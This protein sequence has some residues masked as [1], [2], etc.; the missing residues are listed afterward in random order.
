MKLI[1]RMANEFRGKWLGSKEQEGNYY[2][3]EFNAGF[4][5]GFQTCRELIEIDMKFYTDQAAFIGESEV[6]GES[7]FGYDTIIGGKWEVRP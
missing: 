7:S 5:S 3:N 6:E 2:G 1:E 4:V